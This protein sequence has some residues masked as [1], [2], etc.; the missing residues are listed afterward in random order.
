[1]FDKL[2]GKMAGCNDY[3]TKPFNP[4]VLIDKVTE[5]VPFEAGCIS[6]SKVSL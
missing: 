3:L 2:R 6:V 5:Y 4:D 1:M